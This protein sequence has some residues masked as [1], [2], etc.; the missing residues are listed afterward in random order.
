MVV[1]SAE[2]RCLHSVKFA[3]AQLNENQTAF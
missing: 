2:K 1:E 3:A